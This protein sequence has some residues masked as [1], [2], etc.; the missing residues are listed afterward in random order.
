M[1]T[2]TIP[3]EASVVKLLKECS[4]KKTYKGITDNKL[5]STWTY[6]SK[7]LIRTRKSGTIR[8]L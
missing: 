1:E 5:L 8:Q 6:V 3:D 4:D 2:W 7:G